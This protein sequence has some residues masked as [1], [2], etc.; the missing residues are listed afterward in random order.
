LIDEL[1]QWRK[2]TLKYRGRCINCDHFISEGDQAFWMQN[3]G[4]KHIECPVDL[5][6][7]KDNSALV[8]IDEDDKEMLGIK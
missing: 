6:P 4:V 7:V 2:I 3:L 5:E 1:Y 8:I